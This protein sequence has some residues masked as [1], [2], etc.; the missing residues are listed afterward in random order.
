MGLDRT[1]MDLYMAIISYYK[2]IEIGMEFQ[3][4]CNDTEFHFFLNLLL[5]YRTTTPVVLW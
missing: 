5:L 1:N 4:L 3:S 2:V